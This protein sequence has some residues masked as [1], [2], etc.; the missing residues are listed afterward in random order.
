MEYAKTLKRDI[1]CYV[2]QTLIK[3]ISNYTHVNKIDM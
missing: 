3:Q 1:E 2:M